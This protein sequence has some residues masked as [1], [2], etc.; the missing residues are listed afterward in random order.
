MLSGASNRPVTMAQQRMA[1]RKENLMFLIIIITVH[2][3][4]CV[5]FSFGYP[6]GEVSVIEKRGCFFKVFTVLTSNSGGRN[7]C[8]PS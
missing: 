8:L 2:F 7:L 1:S 3:F 6:G 4:R 5:W